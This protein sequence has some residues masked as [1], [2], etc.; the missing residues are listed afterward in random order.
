MNRH[1]IEGARCI[2]LTCVADKN[3]FSRQ[4]SFCDDP[5]CLGAG[6]SDGSWTTA[7]NSVHRTTHDILK[8]RTVINRLLWP[9][10]SGS[11]ATALE[12]VRAPGT[13]SGPPAEKTESDD[14]PGEPSDAPEKPSETL[15]SPPDDP[16]EDLSGHAE[17]PEPMVTVAEDLPTLTPKCRTC[18]ETVYMG[19]CW[20][21]LDC[22]GTLLYLICFS[23]W[24]GSLTSITHHPQTTFVIRATARRS[25]L[26]GHVT[27]PSPSPSGTTGLSRV[28]HVIGRPSYSFLS[29]R[30]LPMP[31]VLGAG[32]QGSR[33]RRF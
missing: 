33:S 20:F 24:Y 26:V 23:F 18:R 9:S 22:F 10:L 13:L 12:L 14:V 19:R 6:K 28:S 1:Y 5:D 17:P 11:A 32:R 29:C 3:D 30:R 25:L 16:V 7:Y 27:S 15:G 21:C 31:H 4:V 2:C 8:V